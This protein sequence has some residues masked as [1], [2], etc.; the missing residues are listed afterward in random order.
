MTASSWLLNTFYLL[1]FS[2][3]CPNGNTSNKYQ[4]SQINKFIQSIITV[5]LA[6]W[7]LLCVNVYGMQTSKSDF[8]NLIFNIILVG[9]VVN[10]TATLTQCIFKYKCI[11]NIIDL[12]LNIE[13]I[14]SQNLKHEISFLNFKKNLRLKSVIMLLS[15]LQHVLTYI[16]RCYLRKKVT[17]VGGILRFLQLMAIINYIQL[18]FYVDA[19]CFCLKELNVVIKRDTYEFNRQITLHNIRFYKVIHF[20]LWQVISQINTIFGWSFLA[21]SLYGFIET[22]YAAFW[23]FLELGFNSFTSAWSKNTCQFQL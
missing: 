23:L 5:I 4:I 13:L 22:I 15:F 11:A 2:P 18:N 16:Y 21:F 17:P 9:C 19:V 12:L 6:I 8:E 3:Y 10:S 7:C 20:R 1:G 14:F